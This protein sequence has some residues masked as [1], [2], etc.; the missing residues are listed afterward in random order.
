MTY[1]QVNTI[2]DYV[3]GCEAVRNDFVCTKNVQ[4]M[5]AASELPN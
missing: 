1:D 5:Q 2:H 3:T 4:K